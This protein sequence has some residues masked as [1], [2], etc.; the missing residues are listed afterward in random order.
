MQDNCFNQGE[1]GTGKLSFDRYNVMGQALN[2]T[3]RPILYSLC[4]WGQDQ[5]WNVSLTCL[6]KSPWY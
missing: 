3:G 5:T 1:F 2:K 4:N 6:R